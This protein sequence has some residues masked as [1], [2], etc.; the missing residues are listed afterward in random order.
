MN[1]GAEQRKLQLRE[2][3]GLTLD[4]QSHSLP[5]ECSD[6]LAPY[7]PVTR[8]CFLKRIESNLN[9]FTLKY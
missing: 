9:P 5:N 3:T 7:Q 6:A 8:D 2:M 1:E 4:F